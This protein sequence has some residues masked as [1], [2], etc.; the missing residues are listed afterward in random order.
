M[1]VVDSPSQMSHSHLSW[2]PSTRTYVQEHWW[3]GGLS[4]EDT[5]KAM[6]S[7][8]GMEETEEDV[9]KR[10]E[11][12]KQWLHVCSLLAFRA[13]GNRQ[14]APAPMKVERAE[15]TGMGPRAQG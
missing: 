3:W 1:D 12:M 9:M 2:S 11:A 15:A 10:V 7:P 14:R 6:C 8:Q 5:I 4:A 13:L